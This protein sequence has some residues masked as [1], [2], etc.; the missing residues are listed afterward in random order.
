MKADA[1]AAYGGR[2]ACCGET[3]AAFLCF[4][5]VNDDGAVHREEI[6]RGRTTDGRRKVGSGSVIIEWLHGNGF[7]PVVQLLC[8]N[9]N[10]AK[11]SLGAC[12]HVLVV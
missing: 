5:H 12:P 4:D 9:C 3:E 11:A 1:I 6:G 8:A 2:C 10:Q 7:P